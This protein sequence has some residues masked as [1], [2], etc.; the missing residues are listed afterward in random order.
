MSA[1]DN[2]IDAATPVAAKRPAARLGSAVGLVLGMGAMLA[3]G[4]LLGSRAATPAA[5]YVVADTGGVVIEAM[6]ERAGELRDA[7]VAQKKLIDPMQDVLRRY[8]AEGYIV[9]DAAR[10]GQGGYAVLAL[11]AGARDITPE[12]R[13]VAKLPAAIS[14]ASSASAAAASTAASGARP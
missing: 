3:A 1:E 5:R 4:Y 10:D 8:A 6:V 13:E 9:L 12:L 11:P 2:V 7:A 14:A